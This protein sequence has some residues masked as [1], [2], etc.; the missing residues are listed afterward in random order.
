MLGLIGAGAAVRAQQVK[1][2]GGLAVLL[3]KKAPERTTPVLPAGAQNARHFHQHCTSCLLCVSACPQQI[4]RPRTDLENFLQPELQFDRG[5]CL[6]GCTRCQD[7]CP[8]GAILPA[9]KTTTKVGT[10]VYI[11]ANCVKLNDAVACDN[12]V[13]HCPTGA[14]LSV[15]GGI[16]VDAERCIGCGRCEHLCPA[17]P[18]SAIY[19]EGISCHREI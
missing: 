8:A 6:S 12:C 13:R 16:A 4:L 18:F 19:V 11:A 10:A 5:Y 15:E 7:V 9:P 1:T 3:D 17:R 14:L 2:D